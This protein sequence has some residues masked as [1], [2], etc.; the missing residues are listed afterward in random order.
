MAALVG[1]LAAMVVV[2]AAITQIHLQDRRLLACADTIAATASAAVAAHDYYLGDTTV[3]PA[4]SRE[5]AADRA[6][7]ALVNLKDTTCRIGDEAGPGLTAVG[8]GANGEVHVEIVARAR[9][10]TVPPAV[11]RVALPELIAR[12]SARTTA[13]M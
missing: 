10:P 4:P 3:F 9:L 7:A 5:L 11:A 6:T 1:A 12:S 13:S 8:I 2:G